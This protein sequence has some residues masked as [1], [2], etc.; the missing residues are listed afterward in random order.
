MTESTSSSNTS[1][2][3]SHSRTVDRFDTEQVAAKYPAEY[4]NGFR[5]RREKSCIQ[6]VL[7]HVPKNGSILDLPCGTGR[8]SRI[9]VEA[10]LN[11]TGA[12]SSPNMVA[13]AR[14]NWKQLQEQNPHLASQAV[15]Y[16]VRDVMDTQF[17]DGAFD[18]VFCNRLFHHFI[19]SDTRVT[20]L[21]ELNRISKG[22]VIVSYF[23]SFAFDAMKRK[24]RYALK[25]KKPNDRVAISL[26][27]FAADLEAAGLE[28]VT[29]AS[30]LKGLSPMRYVVTR[31]TAAV[32]QRR[33]A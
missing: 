3:F 2:P 21:T 11:V 8:L 6:Q 27:T 4:G 32:E 13:L 30:V 22:P 25:G 10:G 1:L 14:N 29:T 31:S 7:K 19:E 24:V 12:D 15:D 28:V 20:A 33:A 9:L 26:K 18:A 5:D 16:E 23:D 17:T